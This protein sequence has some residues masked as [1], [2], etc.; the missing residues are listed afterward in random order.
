MPD[1]VC[2]SVEA[3]LSS[4]EGNEGDGGNDVNNEWMSIW[5]Q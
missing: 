4:A 3:D 1:E 5:P 2:R